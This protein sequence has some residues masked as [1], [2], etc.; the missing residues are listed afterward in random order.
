MRRTSPLYWALVLC[1]ALLCTLALLLQFT[2]DGLAGSSATLLLFFALSLLLCSRAAGLAT[3]RSAAYSLP[4]GFLLGLSI[5]VP[6]SL[7]HQ[8]GLLPDTAWYLLVLRIAGLTI[9]CTAPMACF[10]ASPPAPTAQSPARKVPDRAF[11]LI[12]FGVLVVSWLPYYL[13][14]YP[15]ATT[16]DSNSQYLQ[17]IGERPL[18]VWHPLFHTLLLRAWLSF[19]DLFRMAHTH[20]LGLFV[21]AQLLLMAGL[22][23]YTLLF[24]RR[25]L[26]GATFPWLCLCFYALYPTFGLSQSTLWKDIPYS[27]CILALSLLLWQTIEQDG[28]SLGR[29]PHRIV[30]V[31][32]L[33]CVAFLRNNGIA[34]SLVVLLVLILRYPAARRFLLITLGS[35]A[36]A[37]VLMQGPVA[38]LLDMEKAPAAESLSM[39]LQQMAAIAAKNPDLTEEESQLLYALLSQEDF[40]T[41]YHAYTV[42]PI[43]QHPAF[44]DDALRQNTGAYLKLYLSLWGRYPW[45]M[46]QAYLYHTRALYD[47]QFLLK[48]YH[49]PARSIAGIDYEPVIAALEPLPLQMSPDLL[50][51]EYPALSILFAPGVWF[52]ILVW[53]GV[54][55]LYFKRRKYLPMLLPCLLVWAM[56]MVGAPVAETRYMYPLLCCLPLMGGL[57]MYVKQNKM[58]K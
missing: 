22:F 7:Q 29:R 10:L 30:W 47:P 2:S 21:L 9:F 12:A 42:D 33:V 58:A 49:Y 20:S 24:L 52:W 54:A 48:P 46:T 56:L 40:R 5:M 8:N 17:A 4:F 53:S 57:A 35:I 34:V 50:T 43:K 44:N 28:R 36:L 19:F 55:C 18:S 32:V 39:P 23:A 1:A 3:W 14:V 16:G 15:G 51:T 45:Q 6:M 13:A 27:G 31:V 25:R 26:R 38:S 37:F 11:L 41:A